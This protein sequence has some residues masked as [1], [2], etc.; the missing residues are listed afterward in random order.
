MS[1]TFTW[2]R[3]CLERLDA[4]LRGHTET[5]RRAHGA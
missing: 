2:R 1:S 5:H 3:E 4:M